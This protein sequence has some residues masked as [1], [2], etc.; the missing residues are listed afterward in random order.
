MSRNIYRRERIDWHGQWVN[1]ERQHSRQTVR[2]SCLIVRNYQ[3]WYEGIWI[4]WRRNSEGYVDKFAAD[5]IQLLLA[6]R[7][8]RN[9]S[10]IAVYEKLL[11]YCLF[12]WD[13]KNTHRLVIDFSI[14]WHRVTTKFFDF[15][16]NLRAITLA[17][18]CLK[19]LIISSGTLKNIHF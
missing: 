4:S 12:I 8:K 19:W 13:H 2:E 15:R 17:V 10:F 3:W 11:T 18:W 1:A 9:K 7:F 14:S 5:G 6:G 16:M